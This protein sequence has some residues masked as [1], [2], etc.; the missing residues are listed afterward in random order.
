MQIQGI[1]Q[2]RDVHLQRCW[3]IAFRN[4]NSG[5]TGFRGVQLAQQQKSLWLG[6]TWAELLGG[7]PFCSVFW[8]GKVINWRGNSEHL[9]S[10]EKKSIVAAFG[11]FSLDLCSHNELR[12]ELSFFFFFCYFFFAVHLPYCS[13]QQLY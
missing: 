3:Q 8:E 2:W 11:E 9:E 5:Q 7:P 4:I 10:E 6:V 1:R 13:S 12:S